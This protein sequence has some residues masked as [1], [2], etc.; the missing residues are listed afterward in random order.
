M[1]NLCLIAERL[2]EQHG[3][4]QSGSRRGGAECGSGSVLSSDKCGAGEAAEG[5]HRPEKTAAQEGGKKERK[6]I[7]AGLLR[8][9]FLYSLWC[10]QALGGFK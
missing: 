1:N 2:Q 8:L 4:G 6:E 10:F 9:S 3:G 5:H 7:F